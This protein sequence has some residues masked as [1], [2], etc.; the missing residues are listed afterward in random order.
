MKVYL[1]RKTMKKL[2]VTLQMMVV[3]IKKQKAQKVRYKKKT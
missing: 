2:I 1:G 3:I